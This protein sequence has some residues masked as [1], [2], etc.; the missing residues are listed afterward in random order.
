LCCVSVLGV[1]VDSCFT[2][3]A[4]FK[5]VSPRLFRGPLWLSPIVAPEHLWVYLSGSRRCWSLLIG[6]SSLLVAN[7]FP[8]G[9][10]SRPAG[11]APE[12]LQER[13]C[14]CRGFLVNF[15]QWA[16]YFFQPASV[17]FQPASVTHARL[18]PFAFGAPRR[19]SRAS[20]PRAWAHSRRS[21]EL[22]VLF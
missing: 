20:S 1:R 16:S 6:H 12:A 5:R 18:V 10:V 15:Y 9:R 4:G 11:L 8:W 2:F 22:S 7:A 21:G 13:E 17:M 3:F 19:C 14:S